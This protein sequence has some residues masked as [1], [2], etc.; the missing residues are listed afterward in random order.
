MQL[1]GNA[2]L[3]RYCPDGNR[4]PKWLSGGEAVSIPWTKGGGALF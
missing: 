1:T 4:A 3:M 2:G